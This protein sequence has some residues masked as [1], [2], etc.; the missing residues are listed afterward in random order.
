MLNA[1]SRVLVWHIAA[2]IV[3]AVFALLWGAVFHRF[4]AK[5]DKIDN[6]YLY[7]RFRSPPKKIKY[8]FLPT[9]STTTDVKEAPTTAAHRY[10]D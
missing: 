9:R 3:F 8:F 1:E 2:V 7:V 10:L 6:K 5:T 4:G